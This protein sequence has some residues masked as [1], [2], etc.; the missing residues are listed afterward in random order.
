MYKI[1][2]K[3]DLLLLNIQEIDREVNALKEQLKQTDNV[4]RR[5][6]IQFQINDYEAIRQE[7]IDM[8]KNYSPKGNE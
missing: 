3:E 8:L 2:T 4:H 6:R 5:A 1:A 7:R